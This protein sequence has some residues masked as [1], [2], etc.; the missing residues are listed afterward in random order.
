MA[1]DDLPFAVLYGVA[2]QW[3]VVPKLAGLPVSFH[4]GALVFV[5]LWL[6]AVV[7]AARRR[8]R[9][10]HLLAAFAIVATIDLAGTLGIY[11]ADVGAHSRDLPLSWQ[12]PMSLGRAL[13]ATSAFLL[14]SAVVSLKRR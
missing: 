3:T 4:F 11:A 5:T 14:G 10:Q 12:I 1:T 6:V 8:M 7:Y 2:L 9:F 13:F